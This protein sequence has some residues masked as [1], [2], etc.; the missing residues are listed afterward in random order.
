MA[1]HDSALDAVFRALSDPTRRAMIARL[2]RGP[3]AVGELAEPLEMALPSVLKH[4]RVL[5][6]A[7]LVASEKVGRVRT[8]RLEAER[9]A[10]AERWI[11]ERR[12]AWS[13]RLD[14]LEAM[15][16]EERDHET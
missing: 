14:R 15:L 1:Y 8:C 12:R 11:A 3:A 5:E 10:D 6:E 13:A 9:M 16:E 2:E 4:L 7:G